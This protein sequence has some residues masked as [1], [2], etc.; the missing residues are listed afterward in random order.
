M[1]KNHQKW[2]WHKFGAKK[3]VFGYFSP[4]GRKLA[5]FEKM[6]ILGSKRGHFKVNFRPFCSIF[7]FFDHKK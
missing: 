4:R 6:G 1:P 7:D 3:P 2:F 5:I